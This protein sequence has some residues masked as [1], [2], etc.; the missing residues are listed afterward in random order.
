MVFV[1]YVD[2]GDDLIS[3]AREALEGTQLR[4]FVFFFSLLFMS[5]FFL[6][7]CQQQNGANF[8]FGFN[9]VCEIFHR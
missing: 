8:F 9:S 6:A 4:I 2:R 7:F 5:T 1:L 3:I